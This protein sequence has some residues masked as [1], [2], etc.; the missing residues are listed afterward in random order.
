MLSWKQQ[1]LRWVITWIPIRAPWL[2][3]PRPRVLTLPPRTSP[4]GSR[5]ALP[6]LPPKDPGTTLR[7]RQRG[8]VTRTFSGPSRCS[9]GHCPAPFSLTVFC[10]GPR[11]PFEI[12]FQGGNHTPFQAV[13][14]PTVQPP[15]R[16]PCPPEGTRGWCRAELVTL[17]S[18]VLRVVFWGVEYRGGGGPPGEAL[19]H[20]TKAISEHLLIWDFPNQD[21]SAKEP[22]LPL[23][24][25]RSLNS[26]LLMKWF[27]VPSAQDFS[28]LGLLTASLSIYVT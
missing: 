13:A 10:G 11:I 19:L 20:R 27:T 14:R 15:H 7:N 16:R 23:P 26:F 12:L 17:Q 5:H 22:P 4:P 3:S 8:K 28:H 18:S 21:T 24:E 1:C 9:R 2:L 6:R 25:P